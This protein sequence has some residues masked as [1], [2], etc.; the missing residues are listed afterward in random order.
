[1]WGQPE[2][3]LILASPIICDGLLRLHSNNL[4]IIK[5][6]PVGAAFW[7]AEGVVVPTVNRAAVNEDTVKLPDI[8]GLGTVQGIGGAGGKHGTAAIACHKLPHVDLIVEAKLIHHLLEG[9][10]FDIVLESLEVNV[11]HWGEVEDLEQLLGVLEAVVRAGIPVVPIQHLLLELFPESLVN[12]RAA[13]DTQ[14]DIVV[15]LLPAALELNIDAPDDVPD[16]EAEE[17]LDHAFHR[18]SLHLVLE[19]VTKHAVKLLNVMLGEGVHLSPTKG[20]GQLL[21]LHRFLRVL[22]LAEQPLQG[23]GDGQ[24]ILL[25]GRALGL[26]WRGHRHRQV[27]IAWGGRG[28]SP[29][30][31]GGNLEHAVAEAGEVVQGLQE[32]VE[33]ARS[34]LIP[35]PHKAGLL[36]AVL[37]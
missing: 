23:Q 27:G 12:V 35:Q 20:L 13:T 30:H 36:A 34:A 14:S 33:V 22:K 8:I 11:Q 26:P 21:G 31:G 32:G 25:L 28:D 15:L 3:V 29:I 2:L 6:K 17:L 16:L 9:T 10:L 19:V 7:A 1:M 18:C 37:T 4:V 5:L 24:D